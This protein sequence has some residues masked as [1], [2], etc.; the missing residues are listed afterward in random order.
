M[1]DLF[2]FSCGRKMDDN[3]A[4]TLRAHSEH[5]ARCS[6]AELAKIA[7]A[8]SAEF[9]DMVCR[10]FVGMCAC[11]TV[12]ALVKGTG[13]IHGSHL[14]LCKAPTTRVYERVQGKLTGRY[15]DVAKSGDE[16]AA[17]AAARASSAS[18]RPSRAGGGAGAERE[19]EQEAAEDEIDEENCAVAT[20]QMQTRSMTAKAKERLAA[21]IACLEELAERVVELGSCGEEGSD[22][23]ADAEAAVL[24]AWEAVSSTAQRAM[25]ERA[26]PHSGASDTRDARTCNR[27]R[28]LWRAQFEHKY[29]E[30]F[31]RLTSRGLA[32]VTHPDVQ[33]NLKACYNARFESDLA[34]A[35]RRGAPNDE[36]PQEIKDKLVQE[37]N[38]RITEKAK[39]LIND[40]TFQIK[41]A[42]EQEF[43]AV[44][45]SVKID[46]APGVDGIS[47][48]DTI[49][50]G[51][52]KAGR[53]VL[54]KLTNLFLKGWLHR[55]DKLWA[56]ISR[57][58]LFA[59][60]KSDASAVD[61]R[62]IAVGIMLIKLGSLLMLKRHSKAIR[63][64][65]PH[66][67]GNGVPG[68]AD[69]FARL[70]QACAR[71]TA[72]VT[73][74]LDVTK[75]FDRI[76][77]EKIM[78]AT[79]DLELSPEIIKYT[80]LL[81]GRPTIADVADAQRR[82]VMTLEILEGV[83]QG[84]A[85]SGALWTIGAQ[86]A[87]A[88]A[89]EAGGAQLAL[90]SLWD[91]GLFNAPPGPAARALYAFANTASSFGNELSVTKTKFFVPEA[92]LIPILR[93][94]L[95]AAH[96][97]MMA[98]AEGYDGPDL[99]NVPVVTDGLV[100]AGVP[101]GT[102]TFI[103]RD[104]DSK[105]AAIIRDTDTLMACLDP[106]NTGRAPPLPVQGAIEIL[107]TCIQPRWNHIMRALDPYRT[108]SSC[109]TL[110]ADMDKRLRMLL[111]K[112]P[113]HHAGSS[114]A[115]EEAI[116]AEMGDRQRESTVA[117]VNTL[118]TGEE[119]SWRR[120]YLPREYG[121]G[122]RQHTGVAAA[123]FTGATLLVA[124]LLAAAMGSRCSIPARD[125]TICDDTLLYPI[126]PCHDTI[127]KRLIIDTTK[128]S[129]A[130][131]EKLNKDLEKLLPR[132][133]R[134]ALKR[135]IREGA[136]Q[137]EMQSAVSKLLRLHE[138]TTTMALLGEGYTLEVGELKASLKQ[139]HRSQTIDRQH[140]CIHFDISIKLDA[141]ACARNRSLSQL[142]ALSASSRDRR[143]RFSS[144]REFIYAMR[145]ALGIP[146]L[147]ANQ[148]C[149]SCNQ[150]LSVT[151]THALACYAGK[152]LRAAQH[153][154]VVRGLHD[155]I[156][157]EHVTRGG[158][159][160]V[161]ATDKTDYNNLKLRSDEPWM[162]STCVKAADYVQPENDSES[163]GEGAGAAV[164]LR[165]KPKRWAAAAAKKAAEL[166]DVDLMADLRVQLRVP[167]PALT[168][169]L[170]RASMATVDAVITSPVGMD[171][172][173]GAAREQGYAAQ[174]AEDRKGRHYRGY[175]PE[176]G[177]FVR[178]LAIESF[179]R[180]APESEKTLQVLALL[181]A[182]LTVDTDPAA[183]RKRDINL[184]K[185][186]RALLGKL[187]LR[188]S[189]DLWRS[190]G[191]AI[192]KMIHRWHAVSPLR[193]SFALPFEGPTFPNGV[194]AAYAAGLASSFTG[195]TPLPP[196]A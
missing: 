52:S 48:N 139:T 102:D 106:H 38:K 89:R 87:F 50:L 120:I 51:A 149:P 108:L 8:G 170:A 143:Q 31:K 156:K 25:P 57:V 163:E 10:H 53:A 16:V 147:Q 59:L 118:L 176:D 14:R 42:T 70:G 44:I 189:T 192:D 123:A 22:A 173:S 136:G 58:R 141:E 165:G 43:E 6:G 172:I 92:D 159:E 67:F 40:P 185:R 132:I 194:V 34:D 27:E 35:V 101:I 105:A 114:E 145:L 77:I 17:A 20:H 148:R 103:F 36:S 191:S 47:S 56:R 12:Q 167:A 83:R 72:S 166:P 69:A 100:L 164:P 66:N 62:G 107:R 150:D 80:E 26:L 113:A 140:D 158:V 142:R 41:P 13:A 137:R 63:E 85:M 155:T 74:N 190:N 152:G 18:A 33:E 134:K 84:D 183:L 131:D 71:A 196:Q 181:A 97:E 73:V 121:F 124:P 82:P 174:K 78:Q 127:V 23:F 116:T 122:F 79:S 144:D 195:S 133:G 111:G 186:Y 146:I 184:F 5:S 135:S 60:L 112:A 2:C 187:R 117:E 61:V 193:Y 21:I 37:R 96:D 153:D 98:R 4:T 55:S 28:A 91:D 126:P 90:G 64:A 29:A 119:L 151:A 104:L 129:C 162:H 188:V 68:G 76:S 30:L 32:D 65:T 182:G 39:E 161:V 180:M 45:A 46:K 138:I 93:K 15:T 24:E 175:F 75:A 109:A 11:N 179:G 177:A 110:D 7:A 128:K 9:K 95:A 169:A 94:E 168:P 1:Q 3:K 19:A 99:R 86:P 54:H 125:H 157:Y 154:R 160:L 88:A 115:L 171:N 130:A 81:Y 49:D 178:P